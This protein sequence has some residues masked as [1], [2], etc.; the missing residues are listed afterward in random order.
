[1]IYRIKIGVKTK[2]EHIKLQHS[3]FTS[4]NEKH[5]AVGVSLSSEKKVGMNVF[6][7]FL[8]KNIVFQFYRN[9]HMKNNFLLRNLIFSKLKYCV[10]KCS[11]MIYNKNVCTWRKWNPAAHPT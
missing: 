7:F 9:C 10:E 6:K 2:M 4:S 3:L 8:R 1:M 11:I 5:F